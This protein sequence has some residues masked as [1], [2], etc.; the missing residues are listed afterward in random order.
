MLAIGGGAWISAKTG[1]VSQ[2]QV[3]LRG[4]FFDFAGESQGE[5]LL[6][7]GQIGWSEHG[8]YDRWEEQEFSFYDCKDAP[9]PM[10]GRDCGSIRLVLL[11]KEVGNCTAAKIVLDEFDG[12][13]LAKGIRTIQLSCSTTILGSIVLVPI[14]DAIKFAETATK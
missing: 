7:F 1:V 6:Q 11:G 12:F 5:P 9:P 13:R 14:K 4:M 10:V 8:G 2:K 3:L